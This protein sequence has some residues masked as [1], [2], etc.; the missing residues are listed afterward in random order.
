MYSLAGLTTDKPLKDH[1]LYTSL[2]PC[3]QC[4]GIMALAGVKEV[5]YL[6]VDDGTRRISNILY[7]LKPYSAE[8]RPILA[9]ECGVDYGKALYALYGEYQNAIMGGGEPP[10]G[11]PFYKNDAGNPDWTTSIASFLCTD[12]ARDVY[13]D[14][15]R[16]F[17][18]L[19][20]RDPNLDKAITEAKRFLGYAKSLGHRGT[21]H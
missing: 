6:Q 1:T 9:E 17:G 15:T 20:S 11:N 14:A 12:M 10:F 3:A 2:E 4:A 19:N 21:P 13:D 5:V 18:D 7:N 16:E 8:V